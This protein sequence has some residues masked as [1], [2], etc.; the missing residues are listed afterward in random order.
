[1]K[2]V[3]EML[4]WVVEMKMIYKIDLIRA[5]FARESDFGAMYVLYAVDFHPP[6][7]CICVL[8][9]PPMYTSVAVAFLRLCRLKAVL[10]AFATV[11]AVSHTDFITDTGMG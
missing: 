8:P 11:R 3:I 5:E 6:S 2:M 4:G 7:L 1:M 10:L 9:H